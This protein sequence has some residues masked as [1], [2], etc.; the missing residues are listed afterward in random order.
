MTGILDAAL[1][2]YRRH[3]TTILRVSVGLVFVW[4]G[5]TKFVPGASPAQDVATQT[6][7]VLAFGMVPPGTSRPLLALFETAIGLGLVTGVLLRLVLAAFFLHMGGVFSALLI[8]PDQMWS[9]QVPAP[10]MEGQYIIKNVV[11]IA[12]CL[13][14][15]ADDGR[16]SVV[17]RGR[18]RGDAPRPHGAAPGNQCW[19]SPGCNGGDLSITSM[20]EPRKG[21]AHDGANAC[22]AACGDERALRGDGRGTVRSVGRPGRS[23]HP[24]A[25]S[26]AQ[27]PRPVRGGG[28]LSG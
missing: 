8:L 12:A 25:G 27:P 9:A 24:A 13:A 23:A 20:D 16:R 21:E 28:P 7:D 2:R 4:F 1:C 6:M 17:R 14:V 18:H 19:S 5:V 26:R 3:S 11:L 22:C 10:T 15:A